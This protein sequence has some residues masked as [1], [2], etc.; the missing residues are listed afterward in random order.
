MSIKTKKRFYQAGLAQYQ[1]A[2]EALNAK[3]AEYDAGLAQY[4][5]SGQPKK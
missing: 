2:A 5:W 3:Q 1:S 4:Q